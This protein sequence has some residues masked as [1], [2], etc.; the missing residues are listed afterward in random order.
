MKIMLP[1]HSHHQPVPVQD[2]T[3]GQQ[4]ALRCG[5]LGDFSRTDYGINFGEQRGFKMLVKPAIHVE[6]IRQGQS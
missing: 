1:A 6:G 5:W 2:R 3:D 4:G